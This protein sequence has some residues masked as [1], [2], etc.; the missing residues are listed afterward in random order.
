M[1]LSYSAAQSVTITLTS[2][3]DGAWRQSAAVDNGTNLFEDALIGGSI[4]VGTTPTADGTI[5]IYIY[6]SYDGTSYTGGASGSD[7]AYT[8]DGEEFLFKQVKSIVVDGD[9]NI[10]YV[11]GPE[12]VAALFGG[13][14]PP[15]WG[16]VVENNT[17]AA[18]HATGTNNE[19][20][21]TG[22]KWTA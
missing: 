22:V 6:G 3:A 19:I 8:A 20:Q 15:D 17:G 21:F 11:W 5:D 9:S 4:Q 12:S 18:L 2:L 1:A 10:D 7:A 16:V 13:V 14:M